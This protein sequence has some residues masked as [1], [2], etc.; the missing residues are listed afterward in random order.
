MNMIAML[1]LRLLFKVLLVAMKKTPV[2]LTF[3]LI[4]GS[5]ANSHNLKTM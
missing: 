2:K 1:L 3:P 5:F 4:E